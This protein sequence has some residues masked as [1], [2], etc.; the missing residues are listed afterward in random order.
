MNSRRSDHAQ[1]YTIGCRQGVRS[2]PAKRTQFGQLGDEGE[3]WWQHVAYSAGNPAL[4]DFEWTWAA[5]DGLWPDDYQRR[6]LIQIHGNIP[7]RPDNGYSSWLTL[8]DGRI[9][10]LD[11]TSSGDEPGKSHLVGVYLEPE[12]YA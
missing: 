8:E 12:D 2:D 11:Y 7:P 4:G 1:A 5:S 6:R 3:S 9:M 10:P